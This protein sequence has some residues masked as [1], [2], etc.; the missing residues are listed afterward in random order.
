MTLPYANMRWRK[1]KVLEEIGQ[2]VQLQLAAC[3]RCGRVAG[4]GLVCC[5]G[6]V[7][8]GYQSTRLKA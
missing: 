8:I 1:E 3:S 2:G 5:V 4:G 6:R 7:K